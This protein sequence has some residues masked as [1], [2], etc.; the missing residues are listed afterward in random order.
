MSLARRLLLRASRSAWLADQLRRRGFFRR[1]ARRFLPGEDLTA[2][3]DAAADFARTGL[4]TVLTQLGEQVE[5]PVEAQAVRDHY[6][7]VLGQVRRRGLPIQLSVKLTHLGLDVDPAG[8]AA[9]LGA[10]A[11]RAVQT[12]S[13]LWIDMEEARY[14]DATLDLYRTVRSE[15]ARVGVCLQAYLRRTRADLERLL[16]LGPAIRLVKGAYN[17]PSAI[18]FPKK[19]DVNAA[20]LG[21][22]DRLLAEA[23][24]ARAL[25]VFGT[26]DL[27]LITLVRDRARA[28]GVP[29][30]AYEV[31]MLYGIRSA[32]QRALAT[33]GCVVRVLVSYGTHWF[34]WYMRR[35]AERPANVW[36]MLRNLV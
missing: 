21:L 34:P 7:D 17:E 36:L 13:F 27:Q 8:C 32:D 26:H 12:G 9:A 6:L 28:L 1:A 14:V 18:A 22:A 10:L 20:Y 11:A 3:L 19:R 25:P 24:R 29:R 2:A 16:A 30:E 4:G 5:N 35:L 23:A 31:H 15:H 33:D